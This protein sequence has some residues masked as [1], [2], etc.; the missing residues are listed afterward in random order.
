MCSEV[1][2]MKKLFAAIIS[3]ALVMSLCACS[4]N[5]KVDEKS[6]SS[7]EISETASETE[8]K[9]TLP[10]KES[11]DKQKTS[12]DASSKDS[13][14]Q[15]S[16]DESKASGSG[17]SEQENEKSADE[18]SENSEGES[19]DEGS[20][21]SEGESTDEGSE[22]SEGESTDEGSENSEE[23]ST[24][25]GSE[26][27]EEESAD[28]GSKDS[29]EESSEEEY[30]EEESSREEPVSRPSVTP[31]GTAVDAGWFD[32]ALFIGDSVTLKLSYYADYGSLGDAEFLCAGSL[33]YNNAQWDLNDPD[34][35]HPYYNGQKFLV[36]DGAAYINPAKIFIM[37][38]MNDIGMYGVDGAVEAMKTVT[39]RIADKC[40]NAVIY[41]QSV[42]PMLENMQLRDLNNRTIAE[43]NEKIQPICQERGYI[44]LDVA[45]AMDD[46]YGNLVYEYCGDPTA[47]GLHFSD[48]GCAV[49]VDYLKNHVA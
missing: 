9:S 4:K 35:V 36:D 21:N 27:S 11:S 38:G 18:G 25:E 17:T 30:L 7:A 19:T 31:S 49:W 33:G 20:E 14:A 34:N 2:V 42:T 15:A 43:F 39:Q 37:L 6:D 48:A 12:S 22:D 3:A 13:S 5:N 29:E 16:K 32:D 10:I 23:E 1:S 28:E 46:G 47:M 26:D 24:D 40:P 45:S 41:V 8:E 44:Y